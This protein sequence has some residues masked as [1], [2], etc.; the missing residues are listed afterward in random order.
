MWAQDAYFLDKAL[1][2]SSVEAAKAPEVQAPEPREVGG[3]PVVAEYPESGVVVTK[4]DLPRPTEGEVPQEAKAEAEAAQKQHEE[5]AEKKE[6]TK[7]QKAQESS[8]KAK[9]AGKEKKTDPEGGFK[10]GI[11]DLADELFTGGAEYLEKAKGIKIDDLTPQQEQKW[12]KGLQKKREE[13]QA[14]A[15]ATKGAAKAGNA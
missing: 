7:I 9:N 11:R 15:K 3:A 8:S 6:K 13:R 1:A 5:A 10:Q 2:Q 4:K 12:M 14:Q